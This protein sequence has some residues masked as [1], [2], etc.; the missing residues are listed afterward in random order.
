MRL[1]RLW[2]VVAGMLLCLAWGSAFAQDGT[3][4]LQWTAPGDDSLT[5]TASRYDLRVSLF[6]ITETSYPFC[7]G[8]TGLPHPGTPGTLQRFSVYGLLPGL[9]YYFALKTADE[10]S[11][12]SKISN[13]VAFAQPVVGVDPMVDVPQFSSP[14]PNPARNQAG[15]AYILPQR[16]DLTVEIF[17]IQGRMVSRLA[18]GDREAGPGLLTWDLR[19]LT[20]QKVAAGV[21]LARAFIGHTPIMQRLLVTR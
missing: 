6:P 11:N 21:Y 10:R 19:D 15:F 7:N 14:V 9:R 13:V 18:K 12:W 1:F 3:V 4:T 5:G 20:G 2:P 8:P 16:E 17:D